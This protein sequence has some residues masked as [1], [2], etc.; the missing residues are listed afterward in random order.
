M[1][2][3]VYTILITLNVSSMLL[4]TTA[5]CLLISYFKTNGAS[6]QQL[7]ILNLSLSEF[8]YNML[9][10][11]I[12]ITKIISLEHVILRIITKAADHALLILYSLVVFVLY[13]T[14]YIIVLDKVAV[15]CLSI[16]YQASWDISK[17]KLLLIGTWKIGLLLFL[18]VLL[19][20]GFSKLEF[21]RLLDVYFYTPLGI[22][23]IIHVGITYT[24]IFKRHK[25]TIKQR[26]KIVSNQNQQPSTTYVF[27][28]PRLK[29]N[30]VLLLILIFLLFIVIPHLSYVF[31]IVIPHKKSDIFFAICEIS[32]T[33]S[34]IMHSIVYI[35]LQRNIRK[36]LYRKLH[37]KKVNKEV[38]R[39]SMRR[40]GN[41]IYVD[42]T[43]KL[44][45]FSFIITSANYRNQAAYLY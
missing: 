4:H 12:N 18:V 22:F 33:L 39:R 5:I 6:V 19:I 9:K 30:I 16:R 24:F 21:Q 42:G 10:L 7:Y 25:G 29:M 26:K 37:I 44:P 41:G 15:W 17:A 2:S 1:E 36:L 45:N 20:Y 40:S 3:I 14:M 28:K 13:C 43:D 35:F 11:F 23:F 38:V 31:G 27:H 32:Y 8:G 34:D